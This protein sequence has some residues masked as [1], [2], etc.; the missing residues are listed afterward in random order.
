MVRDGAPGGDEGGPAGGQGGPG[1]RLA[2]GLGRQLP[3]WCHQHYSALTKMQFYYR[4]SY[5][6]RLELL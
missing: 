4:L 5:I 1:G 6:N 2:A 3:T